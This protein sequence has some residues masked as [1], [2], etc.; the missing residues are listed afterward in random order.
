M[1]LYDI[2]YMQIEYLRQ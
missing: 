2:S 1:K